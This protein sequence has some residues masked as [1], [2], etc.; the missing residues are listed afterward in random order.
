MKFRRRFKPDM[1]IDAVPFINCIF[2]L[3]IFF[4]L[5]PSYIASQAIKVN[6]PKAITSEV[7]Q[8]KSMTVVVAKDNTVYLNER[9]VTPDELAER[10]TIAA[11]EGSSVLIKADRDSSL[12]KI[13]EIWDLCREEGVNQVNIATMHEMK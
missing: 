4:I 5:T 6:L 3:L 9:A 1:R 2:L 10:I 13:I 12:G 8:E 11:E 7:V